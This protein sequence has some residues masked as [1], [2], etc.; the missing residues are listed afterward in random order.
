MG[1]FGLEFKKRYCD[2][3]NLHPWICL[4][5]KFDAKL[6]ILKFGTKNTWFGYCWTGIWKQHCSIWNQHPRICLITKFCEKMEIPNFGTK[7][8]LFGYFWA[9]ISKKCYHIWNQHPGIDL[10][11][12]FCEIM[13]MSK[14]GTKNALLGIF[15]LE[16]LRTIVIFKISNLEFVKQESLTHTVNIGIGSAF[17]K[18]LGSAFF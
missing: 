8:T 13:K 4:V 15:G 7:N 17:S 12:K 10:T 14:F 2:I 16:L 3:W 9:R 11:A 6:K 1:I 5:T 18:G